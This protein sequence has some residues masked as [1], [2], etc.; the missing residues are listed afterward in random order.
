MV[1]TQ[2]VLSAHQRT[3]DP[4]VKQ[5]RDPILDGDW[6]R[7]QRLER[8]LGVRPIP[9]PGHLVTEA[10]HLP[11]PSPPPS[12]DQ[13]CLY[14]LPSLLGPSLL[15]SLSLFPPWP[16]SNPPLPLHSL[17][18]F[19]KA[20]QGTSCTSEP[21]PWVTVPSYQGFALVSPQPPYETHL[22]TTATRLP[23]SGA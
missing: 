8:L 23:H 14:L 12:R 7:V 3:V 22:N 10:R 9:H 19:L 13:L 2:G 18:A 21:C 6:S 15:C 5:P 11:R 16:S 1:L 4:P 20:K 17:P